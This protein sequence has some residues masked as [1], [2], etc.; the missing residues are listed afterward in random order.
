M[1]HEHYIPKT[2]QQPLKLILKEKLGL[3]EDYPVMGDAI[4]QGFTFEVVALLP[5]E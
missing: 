2:A 5:T 4:V 1:H 3:P